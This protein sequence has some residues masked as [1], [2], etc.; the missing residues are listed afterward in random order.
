YSPTARTL[1]GP[2]IITQLAVNVPQLTI[3]FNERDLLRRV[4]ARGPRVFRIIA[5]GNYGNTAKTL[6]A[7]VDFSR[8]DSR[9]LYYR[10]Y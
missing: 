4:T 3:E 10:E 6:V 5:T 2:E 8:P 7:V 1:L 9:F